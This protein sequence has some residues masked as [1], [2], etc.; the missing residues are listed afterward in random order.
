MQFSA[1][2]TFIVSMSSNKMEIAKEMVEEMVDTINEDVD[3][4][5][6]SALEELEQ[7]MVSLI[8][9][10][11]EDEREEEERNREETKM[12]LKKER[13]GWSQKSAKLKKSMDEN[14]LAREKLRKEYDLECE[15][16]RNNFEKERKKSVVSWNRMYRAQGECKA[17][18][19]RLDE[20]INE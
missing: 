19:E 11:E 13:A 5:T 2:I 3:G 16:L 17:N 20:C 18:I 14:V 10:V 15:R 1:K 6:V 7:S 12:Q 9:E 8:D 4:V